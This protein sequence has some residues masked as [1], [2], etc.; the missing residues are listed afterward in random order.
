MP[1]AAKPVDVFAAI[2]AP[3]RRAILQRLASREMPVLELAGSFH[4]SLPAV[5]QHL[6]VL[7]G[8]G[9]VSM[10]KAGRQRIYALDPAPLK[11][12][13]EW[14]SDY[15]RFWTDKMAALGDYLEETK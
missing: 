7:R 2:S 3:A 6:A 11:A 5:S 8:A 13:A 12:V 1:S 14:V 15:E 10:R 9:L 4:M